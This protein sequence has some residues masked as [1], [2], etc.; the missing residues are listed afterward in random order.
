MAFADLFV[1][2][3]FGGLYGDNRISLLIADD[4]LADLRALLELAAAGAT[5]L[6]A[7]GPIGDTQAQFYPSLTPIDVHFREWWWKKGCLGGQ[8]SCITIIP[9]AKLVI[10]EANVANLSFGQTYGEIIIIIVE[11]GVAIDHQFHI[12]PDRLFVVQ[13]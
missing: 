9:T 13:V 5:G 2:L 6:H 4:L 8:K 12:L 10:T 11:E 3:L 1:W 7:F